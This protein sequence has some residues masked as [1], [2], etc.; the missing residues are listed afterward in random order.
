MLTYL[1]Y[2]TRTGFSD[3][4]FFKPE[5]L[6]STYTCD[7]LGDESYNRALG[8]LAKIECL[9]SALWRASRPTLATKL[10]A[11]SR[12]RLL[13]SFI[14][15]HAK[16]PV[17]ECLLPWEKNELASLNL[18]WIG[19]S[20][21]QVDANYIIQFVRK[22]QDLFIDDDV[23]KDL[24]DPLSEKSS[25]ARKTLFS[26]IIERLNSECILAPTQKK[27]RKRGPKFHPICP[28]LKSA[29]TCPPLQ[30]DDLY[31]ERGLLIRK[32]STVKPSFHDLSLTQ[33]RLSR[34]SGTNVEDELRLISDVIGVDQS[35]VAQRPQHRLM[36]AK[37]RTLKHIKCSC[38]MG[39]ESRHGQI[40]AESDDSRYGDLVQ[41]F[42]KHEKS[43]HSLPECSRTYATDSPSNRPNRSHSKRSV[44]VK[45]SNPC[46]FSSPDPKRREVGIIHH[47]PVSPLGLQCSTCSKHNPFFWNVTKTQS[48]DMN[49]SLKKLSEQKTPIKLPPIAADQPNLKSI[50]RKMLG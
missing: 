48:A 18:R 7:L 10:F 42:P 39:M 21:P 17:E 3:K 35:S 38:P 13:N 46:L 30:W 16:L 49:R 43:T 28:D 12:F 47:T 1:G 31:N 32:M 44:V 4:P 22:F 8:V 27:W 15:T 40:Y 24:Y 2:N 23:V 41:H 37:F 6:L 29:L 5:L 36:R 20:P 11:I 50:R 33:R 45:S 9:L 25:R 14:S 34:K 26:G 19:N